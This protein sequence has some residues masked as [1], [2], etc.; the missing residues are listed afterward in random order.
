MFTR[1]MLKKQ[2]AD[3]GLKGDDIVMIHSSMK[4]IGEVENGADGV[5]E[6]FE[7]F[8]AD[9]I[10][11]FPTLTW[12]IGLYPDA[13][14]VYSV[15]DSVSNISLLPELFRKRDG[16]V[17]SLLPTHSITAKGKNAE[18]FCAIAP[19]TISTSLPW[20]S[21]WG[22]LYEQNARIL[23][24]GCD[25]RS[26]TYFHAV[27]EKAGHPELFFPDKKHVSII[28]YDGVRTEIDMYRHQGAHSQYYRLTESLLFAEDALRIVTFGNA[29]TYLMDA[30]K[31]A[32]A[33][34]RMLEK[35]PD[36][37]TAEYQNS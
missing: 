24:I 2:L 26:C 12:K 30:R 32:D 31:A 8:F 11:A 25:I 23:F 1:D 20:H 22:K 4:K 13:G 17:R 34:F 33:V 35:N 19:A 28:D 16:V 10:I 6:A 9:G 18:E 36:F 3:A 14:N 37:F 5:F 15:R 21:H 29:R 27:E 7:E